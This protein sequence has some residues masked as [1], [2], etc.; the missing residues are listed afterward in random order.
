MINKAGVILLV[1]MVHFL[2]CIS[3]DE[4]SKGLKST[5]HH[6]ELEFVNHL[7]DFSTPMAMIIPSTPLGGD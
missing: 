6:L 1:L 5:G 4:Q 3:H 2:W 7:Y